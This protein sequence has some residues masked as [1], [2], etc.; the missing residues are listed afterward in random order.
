MSCRRFAC[1]AA[2]PLLL[3]SPAFPPFLPLLYSVNCRESSI[4]GKPRLT[5]SS[6]GLLTFLLF[7]QSG[8][9]PQSPV[10]LLLS[11]HA[12]TFLSLN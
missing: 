1:G 2:D 8:I 5:T 6:H 11:P 3:P 12:A 7:L 10:P 4:S 9:S